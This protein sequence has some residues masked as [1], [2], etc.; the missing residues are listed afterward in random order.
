MS[1][2]YVGIELRVVVLFLNERV[3]GIFSK[4][5]SYIG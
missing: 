3:S 4:K 5:E 2:S 1:T